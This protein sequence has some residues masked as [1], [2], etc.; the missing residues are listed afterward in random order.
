M[1]I[2]IKDDDLT[3]TIERTPEKE[4]EVFDRLLTFLKEHGSWSGESI[5]QCDGP[6]IG[7]AP[8][9]SDLVDEVL[10]PNTKWDE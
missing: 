3:V 2:V 5:M 10:Q 4:R 8:F 7:A 6:Q 9:L 1:Q